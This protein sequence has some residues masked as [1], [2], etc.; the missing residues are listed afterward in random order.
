M[1][2]T[3][4]KECFWCG[5]KDTMFVKQYSDTKQQAVQCYVCHAEYNGE[6]KTAWETINGYNRLLRNG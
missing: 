6:Y 2:E 3:L 1:R 4:I 5:E